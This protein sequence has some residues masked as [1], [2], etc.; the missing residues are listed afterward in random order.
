M[1]KTLLLL[2]ISALGVLAGPATG[3]RVA[4]FTLPDSAGKYYDVLDFRGKV[5]LIDIM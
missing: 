4:S 2:I 1:K 3:K 5:L